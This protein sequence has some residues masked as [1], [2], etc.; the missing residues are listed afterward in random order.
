MLRIALNGKSFARPCK[1]E[2]DNDETIEQFTVFSDEANFHIIGK[3][4]RHNLPRQLTR[5]Y[6]ENMG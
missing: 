4:N 1:A 3:A 6:W 5:T 2:M